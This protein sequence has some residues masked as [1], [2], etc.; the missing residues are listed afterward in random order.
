MVVRTE[1]KHVFDYIGSLVRR[2]KCP[3][4]C[5]LSVWSSFAFQANATNVALKLVPCF[6]LTA[7]RGTP[8]NPQN[9]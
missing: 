3:N 4:M 7:Y 5:G 2:A 1:A 8:N 9:C 6:D